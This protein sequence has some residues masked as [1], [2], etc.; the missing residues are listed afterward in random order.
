MVMD[1]SSVQQK[2]YIQESIINLADSLIVKYGPIEKKQF[3]MK[4]DN[5]SIKELPSWSHG[6]T[7]KHSDTIIMLT[8]YNSN[9]SKNRFKQV[10]QHELMHLYLN[11]KNTNS[12]FIPRWFKEG[13]SMYEANEFSISRK[14]ILCISYRKFYFICV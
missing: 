4:F 5:Q 1:S 10:L 7:K 11:R 3:I 12:I 8:P 14:I 2:S 13:V 9:I 6:I